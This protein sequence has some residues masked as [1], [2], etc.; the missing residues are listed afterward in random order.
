MPLRA[1]LT[2][3]DLLGGAGSRGPEYRLSRRGASRA[4]CNPHREEGAGRRCCTIFANL[5]SVPAMAATTR[6]E[7]DDALAVL[8]IMMMVMDLPTPDP[9]DIQMTWLTRLN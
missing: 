5:R 1:A 4:Q 6:M 9:D 7:N 3:C 8:D 2:H